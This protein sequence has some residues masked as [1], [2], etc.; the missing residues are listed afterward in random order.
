MAYGQ[1]IE[2]TKPGDSPE[3]F[4][5]FVSKIYMPSCSIKHQCMVMFEGCTTN[6]ENLNTRN[7]ADIK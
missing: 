1:L 7:M 4:C 5:S 2:A 6:E 3:L